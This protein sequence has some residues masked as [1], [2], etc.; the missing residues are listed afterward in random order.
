[1]HS[2]PDRSAARGSIRHYRGEYEGHEHAHAQVLVGL[3]G[4]LELELDGRAA[5]VDAASGL[6]VP[7]GV[8]HGYF[9]RHAARVFVI[10]CTEPCH[11]GGA[12]PRVRRFATPLS[13]RGAQAAP[14]VLTVL[15]AVASIGGAGGVRAAQA[16]RRLD[17]AAIAARVAGEL[18]RPWTTASLAALAGFSASRFR[19]RFAELTGQPPLAW[20]RERRLVEA[21]RLVAA[22]FT[23]EAAAARVGY[24]GASALCFALKRAREER[25]REVTGD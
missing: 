18:H 11:H 25:G 17:V 15:D 2:A 23:L 19:A 14:G 16:R 3:E 7:A 21:S 12:S 8:R 1:M 9:A 13:W 5:F 20:L 10:D 22:G 24:S 4:S 6:V